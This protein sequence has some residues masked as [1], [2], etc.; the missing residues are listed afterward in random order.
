MRKSFIKYLFVAM[1]LL[2]CFARAAAADSYTYD[3]T[4]DSGTHGT[5]AD[6]DQ[7]DFDDLSLGNR[8]TARITDA[9][10]IGK[11]WTVSVPGKSDIKVTVNAADTRYY[12]KGFHWAGHPDV[13]SDGTGASFDVNEDMT[14]VASYGALATNLVEYRVYYVDDAGNPLTNA[15]GGAIIDDNGQ[16]V[17]IYPAYDSYKGNPGSKPVVSYRP[18]S[19][20][21]PQ[22]YQITGTLP[23]WQANAED[24]EV[25]E[26]TFV[27]YRQIPAGDGGTEIIY[28]DTIVY[29]EGGVTG[30]GGAGG[31]VAP[32]PV[33]PEE[34]IDIDE[35]EVPQTEPENPENNQGNNGNEEIIEPEPVPTASFWD[36]L[37]SNPWLLGGTIG[38]VSLLMI[39]LFLLFGKRKKDA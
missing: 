39:F 25:L 2:S 8:I 6:G 16:Q 27:Y 17:P 20:L 28:D 13:N 24:P 35:P 1:L 29:E 38:G 12:I 11:E 3:V 19:G 33:V 4:I 18:I 7:S 32:A 9:D 37:L 14:L 15:S 31:G 34:I 26:F 10:G 22:A 23:D 30:G 21:Y 36:T 5:T